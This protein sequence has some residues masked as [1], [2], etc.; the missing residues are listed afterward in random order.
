[1]GQTSRVEP[2]LDHTPAVTAVLPICV[3]VEPNW[4]HPYP[5]GLVGNY[6]EGLSR[7]QMWNTL[8]P[9]VR[10]T[11]AADQHF[12]DG[13]ARLRP[14]F[15][16]SQMVKVGAAEAST[17]GK[18]LAQST[19]GRN[20]WVQADEMRKTLLRSVWT[21]SESSA[22]GA[23][24]RRYILASFTCSNSYPDI[25]HPKSST[26]SASSTSVDRNLS[27]SCCSKPH[28]C[29]SFCSLLQAFTPSRNLP[30]QC[31]FAVSDR[32]LSAFPAPPAPY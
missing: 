18:E 10:R 2:K 14:L 5:C 26:T 1:M 9:H 12:S 20:R 28:S 22:E 32:L 11:T 29:P 13:G 21:E 4:V 6:K 19:V 17:T 24:H 30:V 15:C 16:P 31:F 23:R 3:V 27:Q 7:W 8:S 25:Q